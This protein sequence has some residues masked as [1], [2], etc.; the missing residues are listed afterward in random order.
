MVDS[1]KNSKSKSRRILNV[2]GIVLATPTILLFAAMILLYVPAIQNHATRKCSELVAQN[3]DFGLDL[4]SF[5]LHFP[6][7][8][9]ITDYTLYRESDTIVSGERL[10]V[11]IEVLPLFRGEVEVNYVLLSNT[12]IDSHD[13]I[14]GMQIEGTI[15]HFRT[16]IRNLKISERIVNINQLYINDSHVALTTLQRTEPQDT[17]AAS[18]AEWKIAIKKGKLENS[19]FEMR[20]PKQPFGMA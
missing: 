12:T 2:V 14:D 11:N 15:G 3:S 18:P 4:G 1:M 19:G 20:E 17:T 6:L 10:K 7:N 9:T 16:A 8:L 13:L 5:R